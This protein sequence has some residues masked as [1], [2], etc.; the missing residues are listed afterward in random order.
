MLYEKHLREGFR[1]VLGEHG[2]HHPVHNL[3]LRSVEGSN[4]N[5]NIGRIQR[6]LGVIA[7]DDGGKRADSPLRV[8]DDRVYRRVANDVKILAQL[9]MSLQKL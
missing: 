4:L 6:D 9:L 7:V 8:V 1:C 5:E 2:D 3:K